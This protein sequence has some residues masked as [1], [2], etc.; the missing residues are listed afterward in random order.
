MAKRKGGCRKDGLKMRGMFRGNIVNPDGSIAGDTGWV[1][2]KATNFGLTNLALLIAGGGE[3]IGYA[4]LGTQTNAV[5]MT[6]TTLSGTGNS[7]QAIDTSTS[8]TCTA[9][10]TCSFAGAD[11]ALDVGAAGLYHTNSDGSMMQCQTF[12]SSAMATNQNFN[13]NN[14]GSFIGNDE[15]EIA[16]IAGN[17]LELQLLIAEAEQIANSENVEDWSISR[18]AAFAEP[19]ETIMATPVLYGMKI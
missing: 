8:G 6:Q 4:C 2:N 16:E 7:F 9:T 18:E 15:Q 11:G 17:T 13:L 12:A 10:F 19:S 3:A 5:N 14:I 1:K